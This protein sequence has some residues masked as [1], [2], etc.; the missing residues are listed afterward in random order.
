MHFVSKFS[1]AEQETRRFAELSNDDNPIHIDH[2]ESEYFKYGRPI[3]HGVNIFLTIA[4]HIKDADNHIKI[5]TSFLKDNASFECKFYYPVFHNEIYN[6][7]YSFETNSY[8]LISEDNGLACKIFLENCSNLIQL[9]NTQRTPN[10]TCVALPVVNER[11]MESSLFIISELKLE[12]Y[13]S[14]YLVEDLV[15]AT[16]HA[17]TNDHLNK[18]VICTFVRK[19]VCENLMDEGN[20]LD[21]ESMN[22]RIIANAFFSRHGN[23][24]LII[25]RPARK[26]V[27]YCLMNTLP[28][29]PPL[30]VD[31]HL[32]RHRLRITSEERVSALVIG[33]TSGV[34]LGISKILRI[35]AIT[36]TCTSR[37]GSVATMLD[38]SNERSIDSF[39]NIQAD[40]NY[41]FYCPTPSIFR[42]ETEPD[43][44]DLETYKSFSDYFVSGLVTVY[45]KLRI[46][47]K[48]ALRFFIPSTSLL[49]HPPTPNNKEYYLAK[50][51][52]EHL[53]MT[54]QRM[55]STSRF[56]CIRLP[57]IVTRQT[58]SIFDK[59]HDFEKDYTILTKS[60]QEFFDKSQ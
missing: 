1:I 11:L 48:R 35:N 45:S 36:T 60:L 9:P 27:L 58:L 53:C 37:R 7:F 41:I 16:F 21:I 28:K 5:P 39:L 19:V 54:L 24:S 3:A 56:I 38:I 8:S 6:L 51:Q 40:Y 33:G 12:D 13:V 42:T 46:R 32:Q 30:V 14:S 59:A 57:R 26:T 20:V 23:H 22:P 10:P 2:K 31:P 52:A 43:N 15:L 44:F 50:L 49:Q 55:D 4:R 17:G 18:S 47:S 29:F 34:G 25:E